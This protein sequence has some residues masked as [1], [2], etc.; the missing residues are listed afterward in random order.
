MALAALAVFWSQQAGA[1]KARAGFFLVGMAGKAQTLRT[2]AMA[3]AVKPHQAAVAVAE[4]L[5]RTCILM[6]GWAAF[7]SCNPAV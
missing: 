7:S 4:F 6:G 2:V 5:L 3:V 1:L